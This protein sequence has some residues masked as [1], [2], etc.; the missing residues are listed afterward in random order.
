MQN[1]VAIEAV[2]KRYGA[3]QALHNV[4]LHI[5]AGERVAFVGA[6]GS[7]KS[8][9]LRALVGL[10]RVQGRVLLAGVDVA[11]APQIPPI[12]CTPKA[13]SESSYANFNLITAT[14][15]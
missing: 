5:C 11:K 1:L 8:T 7:G 9:L 3:V 6:N 15:M 14:A 10:V 12:P 4:S 13:S 2:S